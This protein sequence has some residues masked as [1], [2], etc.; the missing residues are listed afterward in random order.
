MWSEHARDWL[1]KHAEERLSQKTA[2]D[3]VTKEASGANAAAGEVE[4]DENLTEVAAE[5]TAKGASSDDADAALLRVVGLHRVETDPLAGMPS[6]AREVQEALIK[7]H[8]VMAAT[9]QDID[10]LERGIHREQDVRKA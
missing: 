3:G 4:Q 10:K 2:V 9:W 5:D 1:P 6:M 8:I 7:E